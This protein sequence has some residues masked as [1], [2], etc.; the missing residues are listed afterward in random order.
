[1][2]TECNTRQLE[3]Q[4]VGR[5]GVVEKFDGGNI[6][7]ESGKSPGPMLSKNQANKIIKAINAN[8]IATVESELDQ[9]MDI[10]STLYGGT[11]LMKSAN[12]GTADMVKMLI[13]R[14]ADLNY[15]NRLGRDA[16]YEGM[17]NSRHW[18]EV[19]PALVEAGITIDEKTP[20]W[21][22]GYKTRKG[23]LLPEAKKT[24]ELLFAKGASPDCYTGNKKTTILMYY[25]K[26]GWLDPIQFFLDHGAN[27]NARTTDGHTPLSI[28]MKKP[29]R[30]E[31]PMQKRERKAVI[32]LLKSR[33]AK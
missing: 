29:R 8:D 14:G 33:G 20:V 9:G 25:A 24:L 16:L 22:I 5:R 1:M 11:L 32:E 18:K 13:A 23:K 30:K 28:A 12:L 10:N 6:T 2:K 3:F 4:G 19:V 15:R 27:V 21:I 26:K 31:R 17:N 7:S